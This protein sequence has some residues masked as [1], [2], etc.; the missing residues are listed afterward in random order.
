MISEAVCI[1]IVKCNCQREKRSGSAKDSTATKLQRRT[2]ALHFVLRV[3]STL[4]LITS[5]R[6]LSKWSMHLESKA[7][8]PQS[9]PNLSLDSKA[10]LTIRWSRQQEDSDQKTKHSKP[11]DLD[12][13]CFA[14]INS[15]TSLFYLEALVARD[16]APITVKI[17]R[18]QFI[19]KKIINILVLYYDLVF[20]VFIRQSVFL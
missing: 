14:E 10:C 19:T 20:I 13:K 1:L 7:A 18:H 2:S 4:E 11:K 5:T 9:S 8:C 3:S 15:A 17:K 16:I 6:R 12:T